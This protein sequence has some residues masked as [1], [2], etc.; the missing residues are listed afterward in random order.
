MATTLAFDIYGTLI[1]PLGIAES[2]KLHIGDDASRFAGIW[3]DKQLEYSFRRAAM[4]A[5][6]DFS[7]CTSQALE[8]TCQFL[9]VTLA[10]A[11]KDELLNQYRTLPAFDD[12]GPGLDVLRSAGCRM[13][14]FSNGK[15]SDLESLLSQAG[16]RQ[17]LEGI[18]SVHDVETFKPSPRVYEH[19]VQTT[20]AETADI[21]LVSS[22][23][24]DVIGARTVGW[25]TAWVKRDPN[26]V[27]DPWDIQ[28]TAVIPNLS[29]LAET[30][31]I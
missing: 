12:A 31:Q 24:F 8:F 11:V 13:F 18:V 16:L 10:A 6:R 15:P 26:A 29:V 19:F 17:H 30:L 5:Y 20:G 22:N 25:N 9:N 23:P 21:W 28:P 3:R 2:L 14:G 7:V 4:G 27:F 1:N